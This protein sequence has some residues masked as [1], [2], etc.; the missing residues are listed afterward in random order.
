MLTIERKRRNT[1]DPNKKSKFDLDKLF[2]ESIEKKLKSKKL[3]EIKK[4]RKN[5][6]EDFIINARK[7]INKTFNF[8]KMVESS[9][10]TK[11]ENIDYIQEDHEYFEKM[12]FIKIINE[13]QL[14]FF[15]S[16]NRNLLIY[17]RSENMF[18]LE[19]MKKDY[20]TALD[21][22]PINNVLI[23]GHNSG[24]IRFYKWK[25]NELNQLKNVKTKK[26]TKLQITDI[27]FICGTDLIVFFDKDNV[28][29]LQR[30]TDV[31]LKYKKQIICKSNKFSDFSFTQMNSGMV[32]KNITQ[33]IVILGFIK[34][35]RA[36]FVYFIVNYDDS[37]IK[38]INSFKN[39]SIKN[40]NSKTYQNNI[41]KEIFEENKSK[42]AKKIVP[43][44]L[45]QK[46]Q[47]K[48][49]NYK[50]HDYIILIWGNIIEKYHIT[51]EIKFI[52][53][54]KYN[55]KHYV[56]SA[57]FGSIELL[58]VLYDNYD[59]FY[60]DL[61]EIKETEDIVDTQ[62]M[63]LN[64]DKVKSKKILS[65]ADSF[66]VSGTTP[67]FIGK[68][69]MSKSLCIFTDYNLQY[70]QILDWKNYY[71]N[72]I[73]KSYYR[74]AL[75]FLINLVRGQSW[76]LN[77]IMLPKFISPT[78]TIQ[79]IQK[80]KKFFNELKK[81]SE[82]LTLEMIDW[83]IK[84]GGV[85]LMNLNMELLA[86]TDNF[87]LI[88][89]DFMNIVL[90][91]ELEDDRLITQFFQQLSVY[92]EDGILNEHFNKYFFVKMM[93]LMD[94]EKSKVI[95]GQ[96]LYFLL[97][98]FTLKQDIYD[99]LK[100]M[101]F[102]KNL[103]DISFLFILFDPI[104]DLNIKYF[105]EK[106]SANY[107]ID[108]NN[109]ILK[110]DILRI[111]VYI[112]DLFTI[113][114]FFEIHSKTHQKN[115]TIEKAKKKTKDKF[116]EI[117]P[118]F[119]EVFPK[120]SIWILTEIH[121]P[122]LKKSQKIDFLISGLENC[123]NNL[124]LRLIN[125]RKSSYFCYLLICVF[126][127]KNKSSVFNDIFLLDFFIRLLDKNCLLNL[128]EEIDYEYF[129]NFLYE[130]YYRNR[131]F[132]SQDENFNKFLLENQNSMDIYKVLL[133]DT[134]EKFSD[135][136]EIYIKNDSFFEIMVTNFSKCKEKHKIDYITLLKKHQKR[137]LKLDQT[138]FIDLISFLPIY[139]IIDICLEIEDNPEI[140]FQ[141]LEMIEKDGK[142]DLI[143]GKAILLYFKL[144]CQFSKERVIEFLETRKYDIDSILEICNEF[145]NQRA[146]GFLR[147]K[148]GKVFAGLKVYEK[149]LD[150]IWTNEEETDDSI[151]DVFGDINNFKLDDQD[152][153]KVILKTLV[154]FGNLKNR[155][156]L[157]KKII[158]ILFKKLNK[159]DISGLIKDLKKSNQFH[160]FLE[161]SIL[162][163]FIIFDFK[164]I[165]E[166]FTIRN[167][168]FEDYSFNEK[169]NY[170]NFIHYGKKIN[171]VTCK[172]CSE[173]IY[174]NCRNDEKFIFHSCQNIF[175]LKCFTKRNL[176]L[177]KCP[178]CFENKKLNLKTKKKKIHMIRRTNLVDVNI[179]LNKNQK[180]KNEDF[181]LQKKI[182]NIGI[183]EHVHLEHK[184]SS[185]NVDSLNKEGRGLAFLDVD[186]YYFDL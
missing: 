129:F 49:N 182:Q 141:I 147:Y 92:L 185:F 115:Y 93:N 77:G 173:I 106:V 133:N 149:Y 86:K 84:K 137:V 5:L 16:E 64:S 132:L 114:R 70:F 108:K 170:I 56:E 158:S 82:E 125:S 12:L 157:K 58:C 112:H 186:S 159:F 85:H 78:F 76:K 120:E 51:S 95:V 81:V 128:K 102:G 1:L 151:F 26:Y 3:E 79:E 134:N 139:D 37:Q 75:C 35:D 126:F 57:F 124:F 142:E 160:F 54:F 73:F 80:T 47:W 7:K 27:R 135:N 165:S 53:I 24:K 22:D 36:D 30:T 18:I 13:L 2:K 167:K 42:K 166:Y 66:I 150:L 43:K 119:L 162:A 15:V 131:R 61:K 138:K 94:L 25:N 55:L 48:N 65:K 46:R 110:N 143:H 100:L 184:K 8:Q 63:N 87:E 6:S 177:Q 33:I 41:I 50:N 88:T 179:N 97:R 91:S 152:S 171:E 148:M 59:L 155:L 116:L 31:K 146:I 174:K 169:T 19:K 23:S 127:L 118:I 71:E 117:F 98:K 181:E 99:L 130:F 17:D 11:I 4:L 183:F 180:Q 28:F 68:D 172:I 34:Y 69:T 90:D 14:I 9:K 103:H 123:Y 21:Y 89:L 101:A 45:F 62:S 178:F 175:H 107:E 10:F 52:K 32:S 168:I 136:F 96:F 72:L 38:S 67:I 145:G 176:E 164:H 29:L 39:F 156:D 113:R 122:S 74:E 111:F 153:K 20:I 109:D 60:V 140:Q 104:D 83:Y 163:S 121:T 40:E 144:I 44:I 105:F 154:F 161:K